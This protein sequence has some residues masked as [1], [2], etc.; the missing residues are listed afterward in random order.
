M[1]G[2]RSLRLVLAVAAAASV[3]AAV[4]AAP[5]TSL[6]GLSS[7]SCAEE[8]RAQL[9]P[10]YTT[11]LPRSAKVGPKCPRVFEDAASQGAAVAASRL[12]ST[13]LL[14]EAARF[15]G[16]AP[17][18]ETVVAI[19]AAADGQPVSGGDIKRVTDAMRAVTSTKGR[20]LLV[21][22]GSV[23]FAVLA[24]RAA[25]A[26]HATA[27]LLATPDDT[28]WLRRAG[29]GGFLDAAFKA[30]L[31][32]AADAVFA[33]SN[34]AVLGPAIVRRSTFASVG[35]FDE[36][37]EVPSDASP[38]ACGF[39]ALHRRML[40]ADLE[41]RLGA[42]SSR[43]RRHDAS[44]EWATQGSEA[45]AHVPLPS[46]PRAD[47]LCAP[48]SS[49]PSC[50]SSNK[51]EL[52][53]V[54]TVILQ[55]FRRAR[56]VAR[57]GAAMRRIPVEVYVNDDSM[58]E[59]GPWL[60]S[61]PLRH[62]W[63]HLAQDIHEIRAYNRLTPAASTELVVLGQDDDVPSPR[64]RPV[65]R[66]LAKA[67]VLFRRYPAMAMLGAYRGR[68][69]DGKR[70]KGNNCN[71]GSKY[72]AEPHTDP[73]GETRRIPSG[74]GGFMFIYKVNMGPLMIRRSVFQKLGMF[75]LNFSCAGEAGMGFDFEYSVRLWKEG[76]KVG[77]Y[78]AKWAHRIGD[79]MSTGTHKGKANAITRTNERR[80]N[81]QLYKMYP[82]FHHRKGTDVAKRANR[83]SAKRGGEGGGE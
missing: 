28:S 13:K 8:G 65:G 67:L 46:L 78:D 62:G 52:A 21:S 33:E 63:L 55:Y 81:A 74:K 77:L 25:L 51:E 22:T 39:G 6:R 56:N 72:G 68:F 60:R 4:A 80:N 73:L 75:N 20:Y 3:L 53:P 57:I 44:K 19:A 49:P 29:A 82:S 40:V 66:W 35:G 16:A 54:A 36:H 1:A 5:V 45:L 42:Q 32:G 50:A 18:A 37:L 41:R 12:E 26:S 10:L 15:V 58:S 69:D 17:H 61:L 70:M 79:S 83:L 7:L 34:S 9:T 27:L 43:V 71:D 31:S 11:R 24:N 48:R 76:Y 30:V 64:D 2:L 38:S 23:P 47:R 14:G 59:I